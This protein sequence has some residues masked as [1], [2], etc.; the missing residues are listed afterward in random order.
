MAQVWR[1][2][3]TQV[4][5][6]RLFRLDEVEVVPLDEDDAR[7]VGQLLRRAGTADVVDAHVSLVAKRFGA[8]V[9]TSDPD[10]LRALDPALDIVTI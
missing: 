9:I 10:D 1:S 2:P 6:A 8:A 4:R 3:V 5:L 7:S